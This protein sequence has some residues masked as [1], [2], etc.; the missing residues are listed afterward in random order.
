MRVTSVL[1]WRRTAGRPSWPPR[2]ITGNATGLDHLL[3]LLLHGIQVE[4]SGVL[5]GRIVA[6]LLA[7]AG[8]VL[9]MVGLALWPAAVLHVALAL[10]CLACLAVKWPPTTPT[11]PRSPLGNAEDDREH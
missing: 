9:R 8:L 7:Y 1:T 11:T 5:H 6:A 10:W 4:G 2:V 3:N